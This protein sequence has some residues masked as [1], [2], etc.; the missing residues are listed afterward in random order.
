[1]VRV[2]AKHANCS[3]FGCTDEHKTLFSPR[4]PASEETREQWIYWFIYCI[5]LLP[6]RPKI[7]MRFISLLF[8]FTD[9]TDCFVTRVFLTL[10]LVYSH[11]VTATFCPC[12]RKPYYQKFKLI[13]FKTHDF[14][15]INMIIRTKTDVF[16]RYELKSVLPD[17]MDNFQ[18][19]S[20]QKSAQNFNCQNNVIE[21]NQGW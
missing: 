7:I 18:P 17:W 20:S 10:N 13:W 8:T 11:A 3:V 2:W 1:M 6:H 14:S 15:T 4:L 9:T 16:S 21:C 5:S 19:K 12:V